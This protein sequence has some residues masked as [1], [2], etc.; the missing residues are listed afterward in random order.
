MPPFLPSD[1]VYSAREIAL[2][3]GVSEAQVAA[4]MG[5]GSGYVGHDE[6]VRIG[7]V[8]LLQAR[9]SA[10]R[11][12]SRAGLFTIFSE[13]PPTIGS[14][15]VFALSSTVHATVLASLPVHGRL[16]PGASRRV[17]Q[18]GRSAADQMRLVFLMTPGPGGGGGGGGLVQ[19]APPPK[20]LREGHKRISSPLPI[21][22][23]PKP[24]VPVPEPPKPPPPP[25]PLAAETLPTLVAP[26]ITAP[27]DTRNRVGVLQ[28]S[29]AENDSHGP[30][31]GGGAGTGT[32]HRPWR[33]R[34][35]RRRTGIGRRNRR[36]SLPPGQ[37]IEPPRLLREVR[38]D[39]TEE[40]RQRGLSGEVVLEIV[41]RRDGSV[42]DIKILRGLASGLNDRAVA[43]R[44]A[45][46]IRSG[47]A[48]GYAGGRRC[49]GGGGVQ[50][51]MTLLLVA[52]IAIALA[53]ATGVVAWNRSHDER[54]RREA[55][56]AAL[57]A[58]I[59]DEP[60]AGPTPAGTAWRLFTARQHVGAGSRFA[61]VAAVGSPGLW[62]C[63]RARGRL[64]Q[65]LGRCDRSK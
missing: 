4:L 14:K 31:K 28:E 52:L 55:R 22:R 50:N 25:P 53:T 24:V 1:D 30:G 48:A 12:V 49:R 54:W 18:A 20:A 56:I 47:A 16:Q 58:A 43:S 17:A 36:R 37:R 8:A 9:R 61:T 44:P 33:G 32:G 11:P 19:K 23:E 65:R 42:G 35:Q 7:R 2:A 21:R 39:Y 34:R 40:A 59:H 6:A 63:G 60:L 26:I 38:A 5:A 3:A 62:R 45:V 46:A 57:A 10:D 27:A 13:A 64:E 51:Q 29:A 41:V 15:R